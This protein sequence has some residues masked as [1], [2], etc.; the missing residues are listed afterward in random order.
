MYV[1]SMLRYKFSLHSHLVLN[2]SV[3]PY[4]LNPLCPHW[5]VEGNMTHFHIT[6]SSPSVL[7][8][9][10][11]CSLC[12]TSYMTHLHLSS[13]FQLYS[14]QVL[15]FLCFLEDVDNPPPFSSYYFMNWFFICSPSWFFTDT[16]FKHFLLNFFDMYL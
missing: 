13:F 9:C 4:L 10:H 14:S 11:V 16:W 2:L 7:L 5:N 8:C 3:A 12:F 6:W 1:T 15:V